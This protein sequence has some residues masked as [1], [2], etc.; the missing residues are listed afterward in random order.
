MNIGATKLHNGVYLLTSPPNPSK[1]SHINNPTFF[2]SSNHV[3][4]NYTLWHNKLDHPYHD[5]VDQIN[6]VFPM[7]NLTR[8]LVT[9]DVCLYAK[10][11]KCFDLV[12]MD[13]WVSLSTPSMLGF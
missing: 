7:H 1:S 11:F 2:Y 6:K 10:Y 12:H 8:N 9:C 4:N 3:V 5:I 13:I